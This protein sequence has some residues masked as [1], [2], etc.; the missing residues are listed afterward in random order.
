MILVAPSR[1]ILRVDTQI[2]DFSVQ[3]KDRI[4][5]IVGPQRFKVW[6]KNGTHFT[7]TDSIL[8]IAVPNQF[9]GGWIERHFAD[10]ILR[11][12]R[13]ILGRDVQLVYAIEPALVTQLPKQQL[14]LQADC[15]SRAKDGRGTRSGAP[16]SRPSAARP[17]RGRLETFVVGSCNR[18]AHTAALVIA[19]QKLAAPHSL[20]VHGG[21]GLGK[22]HL[23]QGIGNALAQGNGHAPNWAY[24]SG[25]EFTNEF[26]FALKHRQ[27]DTFRNRYRRLDVLLLD[28]V[29]FLANKKATQEEF[30]HTLNAIDTVGKCVVLASDAHPRLI[31]QLSEA[32]ISR[33]VSGMV[34]RIESPDVA[35]RC[36]VLRR[37]AAALPPPRSAER[38]EV[39]EP[40]IHYI[41]D[42]VRSNVRELEG[43]LLRVLAFAAMA[44][45]PLSLVLAQQ[46]LEEQISR[47]EPIVTLERIETVV[48]TFF[49]L[50]P[51]DLHTSRKNRTVALARAIAMYLARQRTR[52]SYPEIGRHMGNKNHSTVLL[53]HRRVATILN[54]DGEIRW[55]GP[56]GAKSANLSATLHDLK[57]QLHH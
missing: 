53:A 25:E 4:A 52:L 46:A 50:T 3:L 54:A 38:V 30:L 41:A 7:V 6:F 27:L 35:T 22:T 45:A 11:A 47:S 43:A 33:F 20:F 1:E 12:A 40:V 36:D 23:L 14:N 24:L 39:P 9:I 29:H 44:N 8:R 31:G 13:D 57:A 42:R 51:A 17:L 5:A 18:M 10:V 2:A 15:V 21:C 34:V 49:G 26:L 55:Y 32:L 16:W 19:D 37:R 48:A 28:D 56:A